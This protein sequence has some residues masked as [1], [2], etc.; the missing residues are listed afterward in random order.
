MNSSVPWHRGTHTSASAA[1]RA[2]IKHAEQFAGVLQPQV[3]RD[4][5]LGQVA[6]WLRM[7]DSAASARMA[8]TAIEMGDAIVAHY[9]QM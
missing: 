8:A 3:R 5:A 1:V 4:I 9:A 7:Q 6:L 2:A